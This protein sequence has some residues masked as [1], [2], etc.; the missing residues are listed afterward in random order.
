[1]RGGYVAEA[2]CMSRRLAE[3]DCSGLLLSRFHSAVNLFFPHFPDGT[4]RLITLFAPAK[5]LAPDSLRLSEAA[6]DAVRQLPVES[7]VI[8]QGTRLIWETPPFILVFR[9][10]LTENPRIPACRPADIGRAAVWVKT[11]LGKPCGLDSLPRNERD[12]RIENLVRLADCLRRGDKAEALHRLKAGA[13]AGPGLTPSTDD[14]AVGIIA[15]LRA[16]GCTASFPEPETAYAALE[17]RTT[18]VAR[19]YIRCAL[20]GFIS[21]ALRDALKG[22]A[23]GWKRLA[24]TGASSGIDTITGLEIG[25]RVWEGQDMG[26]KL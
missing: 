23:A 2:A 4:G 21:E 1:M 7:R 6:F 11:A 25:R 18:E 9:D 19:H 3:T 10:N 12:G 26:G 13:G 24:E 8:K 15:A 22:Q 17:G 20:E 14:M 16:C 5:S